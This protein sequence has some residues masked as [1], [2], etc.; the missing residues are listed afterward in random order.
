MPRKKKNISINYQKA[1]FELI[2]KKSTNLIIGIVVFFAGIV[3]ILLIDQS[4][5]K[6]PSTFQ[7]SQLPTKLSVTPSKKPVKTYQVQLGDYLWQ[8]AVKFY[9][10]GN[11]WTKIAEANKMTGPDYT[12]EPG[13]IIIIP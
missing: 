1:F 9:G 13:Q 12:L 3:F 7:K 4:E 6:L 11:L 10:D 5:I 8:L 2:K